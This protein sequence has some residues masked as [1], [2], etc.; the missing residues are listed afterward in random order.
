MDR[1][2]LRAA[3]D[4]W[5]NE[6]LID[7]STA[8]RI[9]EFEAAREG[10]TPDDRSREDD[11]VAAA[12]TDH[13]D[14]I[15][16]D[17]IADDDLL[18]RGRVV[19]A[20]ALMGG[21]LV[22]V[23]IGSFLVER[24]D[25]IPVAVRVGI[26]LGVP[27]AAGGGGA[28]LRGNSPRTAH[29]LWLLAAIFTGVTLF[30]I[31]EL[32]G[33]DVDAV[34]PWLLAAWTLV[35][36]VIAADLDSRPVSGL[37]AVLGGAAVATAIEPAEFM[38]VPGLYGSLLLAAGVLVAGS[39][40]DGSATTST[41]STDGAVN[42]IGQSVPRVAATFRWIGGAAVV[43]LLALVVAVGPPGPAAVAPGELLLG[44]AVVLAAGVCVVRAR[45]GEVRT[46]EGSGRQEPN[47]D[48][49]DDRA[50]WYAVAP[51]VVAPIGVGVAWGLG[52]LGVGDV[53]GAVAA[54]A[55]LLL[56][57]FALVAAA[58]GIGETA[59]VN[60]AAFG[61][62]LGVGAFLVGPLSGIVSGPLALVAAGLVLL[63]TGLGAERGRR[64]VLERI[65]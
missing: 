48:R 46:R 43:V 40:D 23:G 29:G 37:G 38:L 60:V 32:A 26:L 18:G 19:V 7:E 15:A 8:D 31:A 52:F 10:A 59:P 33:F 51:A 24:W 16:D 25:A 6:E 1:D 42:A 54:L 49:R 12:A 58:I 9:R 57:L 17:H 62:V 47:G 36:L 50:G 28:V 22:A 27:V 21:A 63:A 39:G 30:Q 61:F 14:H 2:A 64:E 65:R 13:A 3:L 56:L 44:A 20:L 53:G 11:P 5:T 34:G 4:R 45:A 35:A 55:V 41:H